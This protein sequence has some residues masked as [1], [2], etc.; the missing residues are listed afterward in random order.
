M[1]GGT[2]P[3]STAAARRRRPWRAVVESCTYRR[4]RRRLQPPHEKS[5]LKANSRP[6]KPEYPPLPM[7]H[8]WYEQ[9]FG[10]PEPVYTRGRAY[11]PP[12]HLARSDCGRIR[13]S[14]STARVVDAGG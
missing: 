7:S 13:E 10:A 3:F 11:V 9:I 1:E 6:H 2:P 5:S 14:D 12:H 4:R 8:K